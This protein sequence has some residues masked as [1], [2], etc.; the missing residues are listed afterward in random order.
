[1]SESQL[2][3]EEQAAT[4]SSLSNFC[5][6]WIDTNRERLNAL[7]NS[8]E[9]QTE[10]KTERV[11]KVV[12]SHCESAAGIDALM[13]P[14]REIRN[15]L[16]FIIAW[17]DLLGLA[18]LPEILNALSDLADA[19][20][21]TALQGSEQ[22]VQARY[23][24]IKNE[25]GEPQRLVVI[26]MGKLG[27]QE[28]NFSSDIDLIFA[29][30]QNGESDGGKS[31]EAQEYYKR[32]IQQIVR[33]LNEATSEGFVYRV[34]TRL[35]PFGDAGAM[36]ASLNAMEGYYQNHGREWERYAWIK[37]RPVAG[38][39]PVGKQLI[40]LLRPFVYRRYLDFSAFESIR[41]MKAM[42]DKQ[43]E[44]RG[45][46]HNIKIGRGGIREV[47]FI[48]QAFQLIRGGHEPELQNNRLYS[49]LDKLEQKGHLPAH[50]VRDLHAAYAF[51]R[52][53][54][55]RLQ[56]WDDR[57][58]HVLP[59]DEEQ[60][61]ALAQAMN[62]PDADSLKA[63]I[64]EHRENVHQQFQQV[65]AVPQVGDESD[66][67]ARD[68]RTAWLDEEAS[69][70]GPSLI[71]NQGFADP[72]EAWKGLLALRNSG[73]YR[74][75]GDRG[76]RRLGEL[77]PLLI[78]ATVTTDNP[79]TALQRVLSVLE[80][81]I[82]RTTYIALLVENPTALSR[83]VS[84]CAA[85]PWISRQIEHQ[86]VL[87]DSLLDPRLLYKPPRG[88]DLE[89][90]LARILA[91]IPDDDLERRM[92]SL[93][94]FRHE[95]MLRVAAAD[96]SNSIPLMVVSDHLTELAQVIM[97]QAL[98]E[99]WE[100]LTQRYGLPAYADGSVASFI[101]VG[102][103]KMGG[104]EL[105]Y[106]SD[107]D[108]VFLHNGKADA[109]TTGASDAPDKNKRTLS[110]HAFFLRL[111]QRIIHMLATQTGSGR[112]Y[113]IDTRLRP[114]GKSGLLVTSL[115]G[116]RAYQDDKAWTWE[117]QALV[118]ARPV[119]GN[120][121]LQREFV[122]NRN[123][124]LARERNVEDLVAEVVKM[125]QKMR[126]HLDSSSGEHL[127]VKQMPGGLIDIEFFAQFSCLRYAAQCSELL[128]FTDTIRILE[129]LESA[130]LLELETT[131]ALTSAYREYRERVHR[132]A[133]QEQ[134][135]SIKTDE[136]EEERAAVT[137][138][139]NTMLAHGQQD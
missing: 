18:E 43:V 62:S 2:S 72:A 32:Q 94:R 54:E 103:G 86:P 88:Q 133:L 91:P 4:V 114:S 19:C 104:I 93:R 134:R 57:Q 48:A 121:A 56:M 27:G 23:G 116:F 10:L 135:A 77:V 106:G 69:D 136:L 110:H 131:Q 5:A 105:G 132:A 60:W 118:R 45:V 70:Q 92:D 67:H 63:D 25:Q 107:L 84:L 66:A 85:S 74:S 89:Q 71:E 81:T 35:R 29:Y 47:E 51:L 8:G 30:G 99:V 16:M 24:Q 83:F 113:E 37:A 64:A 101:I 22:V 87:L 123:A 112:A 17:R 130:Q 13:A 79:D 96:V 100:Q 97:R 128:I 90:D 39:I 52:R 28:L 65:F 20:I 129:T 53:L 73:Q 119:A 82:G 137:A 61:H 75:L 108:V 109:N 46:E 98:D 7:N 95:Q 31:I 3:F 58:T 44:Q 127:D 80:G 26:G 1:M 49:V 122:E 102:Y 6:G 41:E 138:V 117:H 9:L 21:E 50:A 59:E 125:R 126:E 111:A 76:R 11:R 34:D 124:V 14:L 40:K 139:W 120:A 38:D 36:A 33:A 15:E 68:L 78:Q 12:V 55:N 42:I 115:S